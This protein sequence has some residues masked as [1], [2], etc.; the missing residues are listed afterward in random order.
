MIR[1]K[2]RSLGL[3]LLVAMMVT[4][5]HRQVHVVNVPTGVTEAQVQRWYAA[6]G[7]FKVAAQST[8]K[9]TDAAIALHGEFPDENTYQKTVEAL[10]RMSQLEAQAG[11]FLDGVP[12]NWNQSVAQQVQ[13]YSTQLQ[14]Q[15]NIALD[16]G[17]A[18]VKNPDKL[19]AIRLTITLVQSAIQQTITLSTL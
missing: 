19:T 1:L 7:A 14:A 2:A 18:H 15:A 13:N 17:L 3:T 16:D 9:L 10:G 8:N 12:Q 6:T 5:C 11:I 4:G